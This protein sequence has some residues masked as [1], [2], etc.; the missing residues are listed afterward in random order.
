MKNENENENENEQ[1]FIRIKTLILA[2][3][4]LAVMLICVF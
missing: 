1:G 4:F 3:V 2:C